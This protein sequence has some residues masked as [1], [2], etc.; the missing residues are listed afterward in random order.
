MTWSYNMS[1]N[2]IIHGCISATIHHH[3]SKTLL[4]LTV[5]R[6]SM[7]SISATCKFFPQKFLKSFPNAE[8]MLS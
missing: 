1:C 6:E 3:L 7:L 8:I 5:L 4:Y 2:V